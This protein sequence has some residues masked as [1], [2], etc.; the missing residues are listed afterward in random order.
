[1]SLVTPWLERYCCKIHIL[2]YTSMTGTICMFAVVSVLSYLDVSNWV[3][4]YFW[5]NLLIATVISIFAAIYQVTGVNLAS[6]MPGSYTEAVFS[7]QAVAGIISSLV[8]ILSLA[9]TNG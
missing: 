5:V 9:F 8:N 2:G 1:M 3:S 6:T 4:T 7:G